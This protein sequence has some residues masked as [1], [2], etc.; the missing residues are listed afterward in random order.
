MISQFRLR[1][2]SD[3]TLQNSL[4]KVSDDDLPLLE[5]RRRKHNTLTQKQHLSKSLCS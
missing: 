5:A 1:F 3:S 4:S 2:D